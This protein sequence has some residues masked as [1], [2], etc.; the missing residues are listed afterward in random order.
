MSTQRV[1]VASPTLL[2]VLSFAASLGAGCS[3]LPSPAGCPLCA[4]PDSPVVRKAYAKALRAS[5][6]PRPRKVS[7]D[8]VALVPANDD[9]VWN[10]D[11]KVLMVTW[12]RAKY[13]LDEDRYAP[14]KGFPLAVESWFTAAPFVQQYCRRLKLDD[15]MLVQRLRQR[16]GLPPS[17]GNDAFLQIWIDPENLFRPCPDPE[18]SDGRCEVDVYAGGGE[19]RTKKR[20]RLPWACDPA[21]ARPDAEPGDP[22]HFQWLCDNWKN[23]F[24]NDELFANYPW[25]ALGYTYDWGDPA[26]PRGASE[27]VAPKGTVVIFHSL[28]PTMDYCAAR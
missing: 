14:G 21:R 25:T 7:A 28:T 18:I 16:I 12:T 20:H 11:G 5:R 9:L 3:Q 19:G 1:G 26:N 23:S 22:E 2:L 4:D 6:H 10:E 15:S 17:G 13:Y 27:F 8:L 24:G